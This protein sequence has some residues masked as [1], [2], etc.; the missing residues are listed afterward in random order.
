MVKVGREAT[1]RHYR[2]S[3]GSLSDEIDS[4]LSGFS[5]LV[6]HMESFFVRGTKQ[7][8]AGRP[9]TTLAKG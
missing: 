3:D 2:T 1:H 9:K 6:P 7:I 4:L 8:L 5:Y